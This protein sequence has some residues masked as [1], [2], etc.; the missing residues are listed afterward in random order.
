MAQYGT[1]EYYKQELE[2]KDR[3]V[4]LMTQGLAVVIKEEKFIST[5]DICEYINT[6]S[7]MCN[8]YLFNKNQYEEK[9][10]EEDDNG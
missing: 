10:Q 6:V 7:T 1:A 9:L 2:E 3:Q 5:E 8:S 4:R